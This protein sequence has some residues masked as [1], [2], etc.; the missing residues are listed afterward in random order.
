MEDEILGQAANRSL[1]PRSSHI[2]TVAARS[3]DGRSDE[4]LW[5]EI[6]EPECAIVEG[7]F[8]GET[9]SE[10]PQDEKVVAPDGRRSLY[11]PLVP[12]SLGDAVDE[13]DCAPACIVP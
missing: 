7:E 3:E 6:T 4:V 9:V 13:V 10:G 5:S 1:L 11:G 2:A 8:L 12:S